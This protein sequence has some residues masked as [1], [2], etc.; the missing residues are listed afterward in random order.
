MTRYKPVPRKRATE[1][2]ARDPD[3][4]EVPLSVLLKTFDLEL[5]D[6]APDMSSGR[7]VARIRKGLTLREAIRQDEIW[8]TGQALLDWIEPRQ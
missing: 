8:F 7:L 6:I 5:A 3:S 1:M 4:L 2:F